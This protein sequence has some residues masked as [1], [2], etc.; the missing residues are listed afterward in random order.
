MFILKSMYVLG[1]IGPSGCGKTTILKQLYEDGLV[2]VNPTYTER[3]RRKG[4]QELEHK[5]V[6]AEEFDSLE[7][8]DF[9]IKVI[10]AFGLD[11]RYG[12]PKLK[13]EK[14]KVSVVMLR[15]QLSPLLLKYYPDNVIYQIEAPLAVAR[16]WM[17]NRGDSEVGTRMDGF[18]KEIKQGREFANRIFINKGDSTVSAKEVK[19]ALKADFS[20]DEKQSY[21]HRPRSGNRSE[22]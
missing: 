6:T 21:F 19:E 22:L 10:K 9:F 17:E 5:F 15:A 8:S 13:E 2:Y 3:P 20:V 11:Y 4:E 7:R 1:I 12:V 16:E 18:D 14:G